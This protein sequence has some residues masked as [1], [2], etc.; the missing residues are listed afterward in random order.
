MVT[1]YYPER[2]GQIGNCEGFTRFAVW[3]KNTEIEDIE[4][5]L[6]LFCWIPAI[7]N[8]QGQYFQKEPMIRF[9]G[10]RALVTQ[11]CGLDI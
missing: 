4:L 9:K 7:E 6:D 3:P 10:S 1:I 11:R 5:W 2:Q 8:G